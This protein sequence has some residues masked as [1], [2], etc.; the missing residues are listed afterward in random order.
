MARY[1]PFWL[2][3]FPKDRRPSYPRLKGGQTCRVAIV[4]GG[5][6][7]ASCAISFAAAGV[8]V[9]L[10]E[11]ESVGGG[12]AAGDAGLLREGFAGAFSEASAS[13][14]LRIALPIAD[15]VVGEDVADA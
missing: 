2:D 6:T 14:G 4:G 10:L 9:V 8:E 11:A 7:G 3:R 15:D 13:H 1:V 5:L 12:M